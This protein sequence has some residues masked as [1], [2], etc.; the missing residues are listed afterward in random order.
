MLPPPLRLPLPSPL[1]L[2]L[3]FELRLQHP[4]SLQMP[5][6]PVLPVAHAHPPAHPLLLAPGRLL[7]LPLW[8]VSVL[9]PQFQLQHAFAGAPGR[10]LLFTSAHS[11]SLSLQP[12]QMPYCL[13]R[14]PRLGW[15]SGLPT[16]FGCR[17]F[18]A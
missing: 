14:R 9:S 3:P 17:G 6:P 11:I 18:S 10:R 12:V 13:P 8:H 15:L 5:F 16:S 1:L 7:L 2:P 4:F